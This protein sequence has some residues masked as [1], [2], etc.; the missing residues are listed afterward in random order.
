[1]S[2][3]TGSCVFYDKISR[4]LLPPRHWKCEK[5]S[6]SKEK[7]RELSRRILYIISNCSQPP[8]CV[9]FRMF[10]SWWCI[11]KIFQQIFYNRD[12]FALLVYSFA[13]KTI[14]TRMLMH[15][16]P[17][18]KIPIILQ[19]LRSNSDKIVKGF[20]CKDIEICG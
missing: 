7:L 6:I 8:I 20:L 9:F 2:K 13:K 14:K 10:C 19:S 11:H 12:F 15:T 17:L 18:R 16:L 1:M 5:L 4:V 3:S